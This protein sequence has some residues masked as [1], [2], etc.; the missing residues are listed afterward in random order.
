MG[1]KEEKVLLAKHPY[2]GKAADS[3]LETSQE[4]YSQPIT[5]H[6][7]MKK[8]A[9]TSEYPEA[10]EGVKRWYRNGW[11][12]YLPIDMSMDRIQINE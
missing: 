7:A 6:Q 3:V 11:E 1:D 8:F 4:Q 10:S 5:L 9:A 2:G 12:R